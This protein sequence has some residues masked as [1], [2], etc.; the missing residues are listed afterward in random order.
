MNP[1][2]LI[3]WAIFLSPTHLVSSINLPPPPLDSQAPSHLMFGSGILLVLPSVAGR[4]LSLLFNDDSTRLWS[5]NT[6]QG[7][8]SYRFCDWVGVQ[9]FVTGLVYKLLHFRP[10][11]VTEDDCFMLISPISRSLS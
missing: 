4:R 11:L 6:L 9:G 8:Q 7:G 5:Q 10:C 3:L 1:S 2:E